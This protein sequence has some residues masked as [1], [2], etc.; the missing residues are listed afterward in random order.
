MIRW[1]L[2]LRGAKE[3]GANY[4][5]KLQRCK[6]YKGAQVLKGPKVKLSLCQHR[7]SIRRWG[8]SYQIAPDIKPNDGIE[9]TKKG[10][11]IIFSHFLPKK[12]FWDICHF[13]VGFS[14]LEFG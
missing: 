10:F 9:Y 1:K 11:V 14:R 12:A 4:K 6:S 7:D 8:M 5:L 13:H 3:E 2:F